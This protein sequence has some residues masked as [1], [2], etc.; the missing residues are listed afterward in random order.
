MDACK[1]AKGWDVRAVSIPLTSENHTSENQTGPTT[2]THGVIWHTHFMITFVQ[3]NYSRYF[4]NV[5]F[6]FVF[7]YYHEIKDSQLFGL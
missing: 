1:L 5:L 2:D 3:F 4:A 6:F 7:F